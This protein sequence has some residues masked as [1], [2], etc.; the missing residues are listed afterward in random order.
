MKG[1][2]GVRELYARGKRAA[3]NALAWGEGKLCALEK[4]ALVRGGIF[5]GLLVLIGGIMYLLNVHTPLIL[6]D[7]DYMISWATGKP[8]K[9]FADVIAS[10]TRHYFIGNGRAVGH[11]FA[12]SF[13]LLGKGVFN[14]AN[15]LAYLLLVLEVYE[16]AK[17]KG[18]R[19]V[20]PLLLIGHLALFTMLPF[21]GMVCL[22]LTGSC[23]YLWGTTLALTPLLILRSVREGGR[24][25]ENRILA[26]LCVPVGLIAGWTNENT[27]C[28]LIA[29]VFAALAIDWL[30]KRPVKKRLW[31]MW[32][33]QCAGALCMLLAPGNSVRAAAF[34]YD[35]LIVE[36]LRRAVYVTGYG[37][38]YLGMLLA[39]VLLLMAAL[40]GKGG[41]I[42]YAG[43][44]LFGSLMASYAM[45]GSPVL[46]D[47]TFTGPFV[48][49]LTAACILAGDLIE[50]E[51]FGAAKLLA[52]PALMIV[53]SYTGYHALQDVTAYEAEWNSRLMSIERA[54]E[55]G[56]VCVAIASLESTSPYTVSVMLLEE[57]DDWPNSSM[58]KHFDIDILGE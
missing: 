24:W 3:V 23:N 2:N 39:A 38:S 49:L 19:F 53:M 11:T 30:E 44:L 4:K 26:A 56:E 17:P 8:L 48:I 35:S 33:A 27:A 51:M 41:R 10:Q 46:S 57:A 55:N 32:L 7:Y 43:L 12:Q 18:K 45:V 42:R 50:N 22:W 37:A 6:D 54:K 5:L 28:G 58:T 20:W 36:L 15:T 31:A 40:R 47:R 34:E 21:F 1:R 13:L 29:L 25:S 16:I 52:L 9:D 14:V